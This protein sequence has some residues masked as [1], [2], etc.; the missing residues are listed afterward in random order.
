M[1]RY[2]LHGGVATGSRDEALDIVQD[3]MHKL[4]CRY[5]HRSASEWPPL[6]H[7]IL[8]TTILDWYRR[9]GVRRRSSISFSPAGEEGGRDVEALPAAVRQ[10]PERQLAGWRLAERLGQALCR[11][12]LRQQMAKSR[13]RRPCL[14]CLIISWPINWMPARIVC[15]CS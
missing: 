4:V 13:S 14:R 15:A 5:A 6:M 9:G 12:P 8:Q 1:N 10:D 2:P 3:A 11:L 7:R